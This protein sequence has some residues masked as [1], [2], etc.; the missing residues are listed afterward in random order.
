MRTR[1]PSLAAAAASL[2]LLVPS[3][4]LA[5]EAKTGGDAN[6]NANA[7]AAGT[8]EGA[9]APANPPPGDGTATPPPP[10]DDWKITDVREKKG[11]SYYFVGLDYR[12]T[13]V[14]KFMVNLFVDEGATFVS[15]S[16]GIHFEVRKDNFSI[17]PALRFVEYGFDPV[18]FLEKGKNAADP[19]N[20]SSVRS[21][22]KGVF[23]TVDL[24]WSTPVAKDIF[25]IEYG[26]GVGIGVLFGDLY[27][28]WVTTQNN[29]TTPLQS[30][31]G[32]NYYRCRSETEGPGCAKANHQNATIAKVNDYS[33]PTWAGGGSIPN[34]FAHLAIPQI[35][36]RL[37]PIKNLQFRF[38]TAFTLTGFMF[39]FGLDFGLEFKKSSSAAALLNGAMAER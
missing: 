37:K 21:T 36:F 6:A 15:N 24:L 22:L 17:I 3:V 26:F 4:A 5:Q 12:V 34:V 23:A 29:G 30:S 1:I 2:A 10:G 35:G 39:S 9:A 33:E 31:S 16:A 28:N 27:N 7:N 19:G 8:S 32:A 14:P 13:I 11:Q 20:W 38:S 18:L 25:A